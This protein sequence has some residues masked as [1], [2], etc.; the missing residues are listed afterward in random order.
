M[1]AVLLLLLVALIWR[2][3]EEPI[4]LTLL[5]PYI[6]TALPPALTGLQIDVQ[7]VVLAW[8]RQAK[9]IVLS[10]RDTHL[11]D[12]Q[13]T[14]DASLPTVDVTLNLPMLL[15]QRVAALNK[16]YIDGAQFHVKTDPENPHAS[17]LVGQSALPL[18]SPHHLIRALETFIASVDK[19]PLF[20]D[21]RVV[22]VVNSEV[23]L[24]S[25]SLTRPLHAPSLDLILNRTPAAIKSDL[26]ITTSLSDTDVE[27]DVE[28]TYKRSARQL[29]FKS[30]V[31]NLR[32]SALA[33]LHPILSNLSGTTTPLSGSLHWVLDPQDR[34]PTID[35][36]IQGAR[37]QV[38]LSGLYR[39][40]LPIKRWIASGQLN[41]ADETLRIKT[42]TIDLNTGK[43]GKARLH[44][45][46]TIK[47]LPN[48]THIKGD[49][50]LTR[51]NM[52]DLERYWPPGVQPET[53]Q[54]VTQ[55]IPKGLIQ[56]V[57][58]HV[59]LS[60]SKSHDSALTVQDLT[61]SMQYQE[62]EIH[63]LRPLTPM[64]H[65]AGKGTFNRSN[66]RF[67]VASGNLAHM[68]LTG[69]DVAITG[70]DRPAQAITIRTGVTGALPEALALLNQP[71][72][73][74]VS[75]LGI[76]LETA[77]GRFHVE[78]KI[79]FVL[80]KSVLMKDID[81][82]VQGKLKEVSLP[83]AILNRDLSNGQLYL[84]LDKR[85]MTVEG[86]AEW[87]TIPLSFTWHTILTPQKTEP[88]RDRMHV[89]IPRVGHAGRARLGYDVSDLIEGPMVAVIDIQ[90]G[91]DELQTVGVQLDLRE[92]A[93]NLPGL[94]WHKPVGEPANLTGTLQLQA[95]RLM[96]LTALN[97]E[98]A[99]LK[100]RGHAQF[101][102]T[103][104][105]GR[106]HLS[107]IVLGASDLRDVAIQ[108][109]DPG[110]SMTIGDG[111]LDVA[112][113]QPLLR[114][115]S[116]EQRQ[117]GAQPLTTSPIHLH[118]P[119]L[120]RVQMAPGR[121]LRNVSAHLVWNG[122]SWDR[123][124][125]S[126][127]VPSELTRRPNGASPGSDNDATTFDFRY[128]PIATQQPHLSLR[129]NDLGSVLR[130]LNTYD[131]LIG[132]KVT[133][134]GRHAPEKRGIKTKLHAAE[135]TVQQAPV[136][137]HVLAAASLHGLTNL[138]SNNGLKFANLN[139]DMT[140]YDDRLTIKRSKAHGGSL[141]VTARGDITYQ[142]GDLDLRGTIIPAYLLNSILGQVPVVN[143]LVG[144]KGQ[145]LVAV[146]Y[147]LTGDLA[148]PHVSVN[149]ISALT[150]GF[151][152][153]VF[154]LLKPNK[155]GHTQPS[156]PTLA[157]E[158]EAQISE[159]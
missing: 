155:E 149:P 98:S 121:Y 86:Q 132:G 100:A 83:S 99:T 104:Q 40:P 116:T 2:L 5:T 38:A 19:Y 12:A 15:R 126:G 52:A 58:A 47:G 146:N 14:I 140:L 157:P 53:R 7:D 63:Y 135:F 46:S 109:L 114:H 124:T 36:H 89:I 85:Q 59:V 28:T 152:R 84:N 78:P 103:P 138:L 13:G 42:S 131:N 48:P 94:N 54:W 153:G 67:Q 16:V 129:T 96:A 72:L 24:Y 33:A 55:N 106:F 44:L 133:L 22:H 148:K 128:L 125:V 25:P 62:L 29:R 66:F 88:W 147:H 10:A 73:N 51:F 34:W 102:G 50:T 158:P 111:F 65:V 70:L 115:P 110:L 39:Q 117:N 60:A 76:P 74:L 8:H 134:T 95:N 64:Q 75:D 37:G 27:F 77:T 93:L 91:W 113:L 9:R 97:F 143:L 61:G 20:A 82:R 137:A 118:L 130:A 4:S 144:G 108:P 26:S 156:S 1:V 32:P 79:A 49:I 87:A 68:A 142:T 145:G 120:H 150:P 11:R 112:S 107:H 92:T 123:I 56:Q 41:G 69:G 6:E 81:I 151:L 71:R 90:T 21:L 139:A 43:N 3:V 127:R 119:R 105:G 122:A 17:K 23:T 31:I 159:P 57:K 80:S 35:F 18:P 141:G 45:Q 136:V 101:D 30:D 154:G